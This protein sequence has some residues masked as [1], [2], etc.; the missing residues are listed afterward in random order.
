MAVAARKAVRLE[1]RLI[2]HN[3]VNALLGYGSTA[4]LLRDLRDA[5]EGFDSGGRSYVYHHLYARGDRV[6]V[7]PDDL[8]RYDDSIRLHLAEINRNRTEPIT[9]KYFQYLAA[10]YVEVFL[11]RRFGRP[12]ALLRELNAFAERQEDET[13]RFEEGDLDKLAFWM[14]TGSG[15]TLLMH[16]NYRQFLRYNDEPLDNVLLITPNE[17]LT[18]QH[19]REMRLSGIPCERFS[20]ARSGLGLDVPDTVRATEITK[21]TENKQGGGVSVDVEAFEG[22]NLIFVDEGHKGAVSSATKSGKSWRGLRDRLDE[23]GF[24]FEYSATFGQALSKNNKEAREL[25]EEYGRAILFDYSYRYFYDD[26]YGKDFQILNLKE[27]SEEYTDLLL[28]GNLLSFYQ[29][30]RCFEQLDGEVKEYNLED[31]LWIFVGSSVSKEKGSDVYLVARFLHRFLRNEGDWSVRGIERLL[32]GESGLEDGD[33]RDAFERRFG[34]LTGESARDVY[35][36]VLRSVFHAPAGGALR[37]ADIKGAGGELG[38]KV[39][40]AED[41]FGLIYIGDTPAFKKLLEAGD[42]GVPLEEDAIGDSL[43]DG[44]NGAGSPINVLV[45]ARKFTEGWSSWRVSNMGLLNVGQGEGPMIIQLFG[46]G[47]RLKGRDFSLKRSGALDGRHPD[48]VRLLETLDIFGMRADYMSRFKEDLEREGVDPDGYEEMPRL[49]IRKNEEFLEAGLV[50]PVPPEEE[51]AA[52]ERVVLGVEPGLKVS[53]DLSARLE[54]ARMGGGGLDTRAMRAGEE[55]Y[56]EPKFLSM[57]DWSSIHLDLL[58]FKNARSLWNLILPVGTPRRIMEQSEPAYSLIA[59]QSVVEPRDFE[60]LRRLQEVVHTLLR[61]YVERFYHLH[62]QRWDSKHMRLEGLT[63]EHPNFADYAVKVKRSER[64]LVREVRALIDRADEVYDRDLKTLPAIHLDRHLYQPLLVDR[65]DDVKSTPAGLKESERNFVEA[66]RKYLKERTDG[67]GREVFLL[68]NLS[69]GKGVGFFDT[70]GFYPDFILWVKYAGGSQKVVFVEP[71]GMRNDNPPPHNDKVNLYLAL[72]D[73]SDRFARDDEPEVFLDSYIVSATPFDQL[74]EKWGGG[75]TRERFAGKHV[76]FEDGLDA[77]LEALLA[78]RD[79]LERRISTSYPPPLA[80]GY[81]SLMHT[82]D[83]GGLYREQLRFAENV[84]AFLASVS[85]ALLREEDRERA[86]LDLAAYWRGGISP[87]DWKDIIRRCS[88]VF[89]GYT[90]LPLATAIYGLKIG[91]EQRGFG[92]DIVELIRAKNDYKHDRGPTEPEDLAEA[93]DKTQEKLRRCMEAL[94]FL[95]DY[96]MR[97]AE[98]LD[99]GGKPRTHGLFLDAGDVLIPLFPF[100]TSA[101]CLRCEETETYFVDAWDRKKNVARLKSFERGHTTTSGEVSAA[102]SW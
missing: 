4:E 74:S 84:L 99:P 24:T 89:A 43:F 59:D 81:R 23:R 49:P 80:R 62:Q 16:L 65:N 72:R 64:D 78:P 68:R 22:R 50:I 58:E 15:K 32:E 60:G 1:K 40:G 102:L 31:P 55:R 70:A 27:G 34:R 82:G 39:A 71:H 17:G 29:Q 20:G 26:G 7:P 98:D 87:G 95:A 96:P 41:Y 35:R 46:R 61:K 28:L 11:D 36:D 45:G 94:D 18:E 92:R 76:L 3:W 53:L 6:G 85:L 54:T 42:E 5:A 83:P 30:K 38:L 52:S 37:V 47:V 25:A 97:E 21:L 66:L 73:L 48:G 8:E 67:S 33:G 9:L 101:T 88:K 13:I 57:L 56:I 69:R 90:D 63:G 10:L 12:E 51:F 86:G 2:L 100:I 19:L 75:W 77:G 93:S 79:G 14:A 91:S 44:I